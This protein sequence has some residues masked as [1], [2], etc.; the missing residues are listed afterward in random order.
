METY[1]IHVT[2]QCNL[3]CTYCYEDDKQSV[4]PWKEVHT[5]LEN[6]VAH[7]KDPKFVIE[8]LGGEPMLAFD[9]IKKAV[10]F[11][12]PTGRVARYVITTNGTIVSD[13]VIAFLQQHTNVT[14][15]I[16]MDGTRTMNQLRVFKETRKNSYD[17][18]AANIKTLLASQLQPK[19]VQVHMV[20]HPYNV[21]S[22]YRGIQHLYRLGIRHI[23]I[24]TIEKTME[25]TDEYCHRFI[26]EMELV[27]L[28]I[29]SQVFPGLY[30]DIL[31]WLKPKSD[32]RTYLRD[33]LTN[34][35]VAETYGRTT[36]AD[37]TSAG[38]YTSHVGVSKLGD[39]IFHLRH[40]VYRNHRSTHFTNTERSD[41]KGG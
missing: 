7:N 41:Q 34:Q 38:I 23:G 35:V 29:K 16:S 28:G 5:L 12:D 10:K 36:E 8:F 4:Y 18:V 1:V 19:Q 32:K 33:P 2:K 26:A 11:L 31:E 25:L 40:T 39:T 14:F 27:S 37:V 9:H 13:D 22:L 17:V 24:G 20:T 3:D 6:I 30:V 15:A 21:A